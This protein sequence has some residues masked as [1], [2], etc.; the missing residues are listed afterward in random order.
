MTPKTILYISKFYTPTTTAAGIR[1]QRFVDALVSAGY[2]VI[3]LT[4]GEAGGLE[5]VKENLWIYRI[6]QSQLAEFDAGLIQSSR[7]P[8][9]SILP[10]PDP[11]KDACL[12]LFAYGQMLFQKYQ[13]NA[14][15]A[16]APPFSFMAVAQRLAERFNKHLILDFRD[17]WFIAM[18]WPYANVLCRLSARRWERRCVKSAD[19]IIVATETMRKNL[20]EA[21]G[22]ELN[23]RIVTVRHGYA[24]S[25][26]NTAEVDSPYSAERPLRIVYTGQLR[27]I[28]IDAASRIS[29]IVQPVVHALLRY[30]IGATFCKNLNIEWMS[31][32]NLFKALAQAPKQD[33]SFLEKIR[34]D[35]IGQKFPQIEKWT[36]QLG[37][38]HIVTQQGPMPPNQAEQAAQNAD[39]LLLNLYG[40]KNNP[41]HWCVPSKVYTYMG[42]GKPILALV[43]PGETADLVSDAGT[44]LIVHP[45]DINT[46]TSH[47]L[48]LTQ[49]DSH[50]ITTLKPNWPSI[51]PYKVSNQQKKLIQA[52]NNDPQP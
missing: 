11:D 39:L 27:G 28:D 5:E 25:S 3:V 7:W 51:E 15:L 45:E 40:I 52:I 36:Q 31:P 34:I 22:Q 12:A 9:G 13:P 47:L 24:L 8:I 48:D 19:K 33:D 50:L 17:A 46:L 23:E 26:N 35:F 18:P 10:G 30:T 29:R 49:P 1:T 6:G 42:T 2:R 44:A 4:F 16:S 14:V 41:Y 20:I 38:T 32:L 37:L 43:P 21:Y